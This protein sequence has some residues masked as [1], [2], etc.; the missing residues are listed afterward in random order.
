[1]RS[2]KSWL[3]T[4][5]LALE[6]KKPKKNIDPFVVQKDEEPATSHLQ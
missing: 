1:M 3:G 2:R 5:G 4:K 6:G